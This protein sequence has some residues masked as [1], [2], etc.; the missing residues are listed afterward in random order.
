MAESERIKETVKQAT[1][2]LATSVM[3]T[4]TDADAGCHP[5]SMTSYRELQRIGNGVAVL[6]KPSFNW[7]W[8][9]QDRYAK[10]M[11]FEMDVMNILETRGY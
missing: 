6:V 11:N 3:I 7:D 5:N 4:F 8:D 1:I 2:Q 9:A 10:L